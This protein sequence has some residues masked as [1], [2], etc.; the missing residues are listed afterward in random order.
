MDYHSENFF[1]KFFSKQ[2]NIS[3]FFHV[4]YYIERYLNLE[5]TNELN[6]FYCRN[7]HI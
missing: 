4:F 3:N 1:V 2:Y 6:I 5:K 7:K